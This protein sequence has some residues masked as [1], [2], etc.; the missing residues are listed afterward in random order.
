MTGLTAWAVPENCPDCGAPLALDD[1]GTGPA[2]VDC[3]SCDY[4]DTWTVNDPAGDTR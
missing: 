1:D 4:A 2:R 3:A